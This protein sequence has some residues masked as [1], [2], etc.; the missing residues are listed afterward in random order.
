MYDFA[1]DIDGSIV[2]AGQFHYLGGEHV[3]PLLRYKNGAWGPARTTW[4]LQPPGSG[5]S[6]IAIDATAG[7]RSR[8]TTT[9]AT[10]AA[11]SGSMTAPGCA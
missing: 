10:A 8:H 1:R 5:F 6:A 9:S 11:R 3:E 7:S 2:A 4:E